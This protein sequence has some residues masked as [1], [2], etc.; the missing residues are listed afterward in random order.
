[1]PLL[2]TAGGAS[3][4]GFRPY[5]T[6]AVAAFISATGGTI[7]TSGNYKIHTFTSSG[8]FSVTSAPSGKFLDFVVVG[9][10]GGSANQRGGGAGGVVYKTSQSPSNGSYTVTVGSGGALGTATGTDGGDSSFFGFT[11]LGGGGGVQVGFGRSGG[12]G[13]AGT[14]GGGAGL[15]PTSASGGFGNA[16]G[17]GGGGGAGSAGGANAGGS[18]YTD[19]ITGNEYSAGGPLSTDGTYFGSSNRGDGGGYED[20]TGTGYSGVAGTVVIRYLYQ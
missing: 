11:A 16:G 18:G 14:D 8:T 15:Q 3:I 9:G 17:T 20:D 6:E 13:G 4:R 19:P 12:S 7:T 10:G 5:S 1:M 2:A